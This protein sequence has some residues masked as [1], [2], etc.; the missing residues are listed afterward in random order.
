MERTP[1]LPWHERAKELV[2][3][4][5]RKKGKKSGASG[6]KRQDEAMDKKG[7]K[8]TAAERRLEKKI[9]DRKKDR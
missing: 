6:L 3:V 8:K 5:G 2:V 9:G 4:A 7:G 1:A